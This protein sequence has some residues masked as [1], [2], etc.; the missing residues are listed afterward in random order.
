M[1]RGVMEIPF[2]LKC[3][4]TD[5]KEQAELNPA[6]SRVLN[7]SQFNQKKIK[8]QKAKGRGKHAGKGHR[9]IEQAAQQDWNRR[10]RMRNNPTKDRGKR[11]SWLLL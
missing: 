4:I 10:K 9:R 1:G 7:T 3:A 11:T 5:L 8:N 2:W 6:Q